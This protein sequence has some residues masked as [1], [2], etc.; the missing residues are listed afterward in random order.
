MVGRVLSGEPRRCLLR[1]PSLLAILKEAVD[2]GV[3]VV[4]IT[5]CNFGTVEL[6]LYET[7]SHLAEVCVCVHWCEYSFDETATTLVV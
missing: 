7:G 4:G 6:D 5:Q 3:A 2:R 1:R